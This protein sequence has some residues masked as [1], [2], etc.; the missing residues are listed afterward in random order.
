[1]KTKHITDL[2]SKLKA[3]TPDYPSELMAAK[4]AAFL[5]QAVNIKID[6]KGQGGEGGQQGGSGGSGAALGGGPAT[7]SFLLQALVGI[8]IVTAMFLA[9]YAYREQI[10]DML[11]DNEP[12]AREQSS[13]PLAA[14]TPLA[15]GTVTAIPSSIPS[16]L[17]TSPVETVPSGIPGA[18][19][20][21]EMNGASVI[22]G[23]PGAEIA[24]DKIKSDNGLHL[25]QTPGTPAAP[26]H[27]NPGNINKPDKNKPD[28]PDKPEKPEKP[29]KPKKP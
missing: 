1:M 20:N 12:V 28:K 27:G 7:S 6:G 2:L 21:T 9:A 17:A 22:A 23:T 25:G 15:P 19:D 14:S 11:Q 18:V 4:K 26:G 13:Q 8:S 5:K 16:A 29:E 24:A 3:E 10:T